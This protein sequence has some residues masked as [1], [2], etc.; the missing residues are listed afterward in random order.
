MIQYALH[1][2]DI[3]IHVHDVVV[4]GRHLAYHV[5]ILDLFFL[6]ASLK[7]LLANNLDSGVLV[8]TEEGKT[9]W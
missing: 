1:A 6:G 8:A 5:P 7:F 2:L 4:G 9:F 3:L